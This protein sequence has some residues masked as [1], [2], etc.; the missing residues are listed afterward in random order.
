MYI[1]YKIHTHYMFNERNSEMLKRVR[2][3]AGYL[4]NGECKYDS[5]SDKNVLINKN[6]SNNK[7]GLFEEQHFYI[8]RKFSRQS[9]KFHYNS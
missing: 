1:H 8:L 2:N 6:V 7:C 4:E 9:S 5:M 3:R